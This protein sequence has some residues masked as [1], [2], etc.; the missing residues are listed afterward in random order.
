M[1]FRFLFPQISVGPNTEN[2]LIQTIPGDRLADLVGRKSFAILI[3]RSVYARGRVLSTQRHEVAWNGAAWSDPGA[4][5]FRLAAAPAFDWRDPANLAFLETG[6]SMLSD[7]EFAAPDGLAFYSSYPA[8]SGKTY[9]SDNALKYGERNVIATHLRFGVLVACYPNILIDL[10]RDITES[11]LFL[12]PYRSTVSGTV[13]LEGTAASRNVAIPTL[14][15]LRF[16]LAE[17]LPRGSRAWQGT[18]FV[19]SKARPVLMFCKHSAAQ[20]NVVTTMEHSLAYYADDVQ[21][22]A[23]QRARALFGQHVLRRIEEWR[24]RRA[25]LKRALA[26]R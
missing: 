16:D 2:D 11:I 9:F 15:G 21:V 25:A 10:D 7:G 20:P 4:F 6:I 3:E 1:G 5:Q 12:N 26:P 13:E 8:A 18:V 23:T 22:A 14:S 19:T 17:M 24:G